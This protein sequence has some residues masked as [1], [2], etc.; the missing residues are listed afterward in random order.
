ME[1]YLNF[2]NSWSQQPY[3]DVIVVDASENP[4]GC[5]ES[6][7]EELIYEVWPGTKGVCDCLER[8]RDRE[9]YLGIHCEKEGKSAEHKDDDCFEISARN[10]IV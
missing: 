7:P 4:L 3:V 5:P 9:Y 8:Y 1:N 6:H 2:T 10:P